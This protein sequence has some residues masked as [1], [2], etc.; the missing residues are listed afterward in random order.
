[1]IKIT[2]EV[3]EKEENTQVKMKNENFDKGTNN[4]KMSALQIISH[5]KK[6]FEEV[7][8]TKTE[9]KKKKTTRKKKEN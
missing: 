8:A 5:I 2:L 4:E 3:E 9:E 7:D 1:M 6:L